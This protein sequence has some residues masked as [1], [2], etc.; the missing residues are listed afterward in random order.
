MRESVFIVSSWKHKCAVRARRRRRA[1]ASNA[2]ESEAPMAANDLRTLDIE[3]NQLI[4]GG[5]VFEALERFYDKDIVMQENNDE[6]CRG[7]A[8]NIEREKQF[9][10]LVEAYHGSKVTAHAV[11]DD[12]TFSEWENDVTFKGAPR[13]TTHQ[14]SVRRWKNGKIVHERFYHK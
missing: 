4:L 11:G 5:K 12:T 6:P 10:T 2:H 1:G 8:T 9:F 7:L 3:L 14:V 13:A